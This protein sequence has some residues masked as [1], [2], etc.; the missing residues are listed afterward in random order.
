MVPARSLHPQ[1]V[2]CLLGNAHLS[3]LPRM[4]S[5]ASVGNWDDGGQGNYIYPIPLTPRPRR[6]L[7]RL[8]FHHLRS[9]HQSFP[10]SRT[11]LLHRWRP[12]QPALQPKL[13]PALPAPPVS[14]PPPFVP[15]YTDLTVLKVEADTV[16][17]FLFFP[18]SS[19]SF[20]CLLLVLISQLS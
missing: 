6:R 15:S 19:P 14:G 16:H 18:S 3:S 13:P 5:R 8:N 12:R 17:P 10:A 2:Q 4:M 9:C 20:F 11:L 1:W 7:K